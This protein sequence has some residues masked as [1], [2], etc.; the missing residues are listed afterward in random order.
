MI[1]ESMHIAIVLLLTVVVFIA[2]VRETFPPDVVAMLA[3]GV[4][5]V[6]GILTSKEALT[7]FSNAGPIAVG[8]MFVLSAAIERTG[9]IDRFGR[10]VIKSA[11]FSPILVLVAF[12]A[13]VMSL[14][15][16]IN[17]TPVVVI[18]TP[19]AVLLART[20]KISPSRLLIPL[21]Y[22]SIFGGTTTLIGT[23]TNLL[24]AGLVSESGQPPITMFEFTLPGV[25]M[26]LV[27]VAYLA[28]FGRWLLPDRTVTNVDTLERHFVTEFVVPKDSKL[29]GKSL[30]N[31][32]LSGDR[33]VTFLD[34]IRDGLSLRFGLEPI[35]LKAGD[36]VVVRSNA[37]DVMGLR[38][39]HEISASTEEP[40]EEN[41]EVRKVESHATRLMEG[42]VAPQSRLRGYLVSDLNFRRLFGVYIVAIYRQGSQL[43]GGFDKIVLMP[44]DTLLLEG[45][46]DGLR[47]LFERRALV[48]LTEPTDAPFRR[49]KAPI[50]AAAVILVM[51][52]A[53]FNIMP[54]EILA[55]VAAAVVVATGCLNTEEAYEAIQWPV[56]ML[57]FGM[58]AVGMAMEKTGAAALIVDHLATI[59]GGLGPILVVA[60]IYLVT[61]VLTEIVSNNA[62]AVLLTP[63]AVRLAEQMSVNPRPFI[64]AVLFAASASF[65]TPIGY[66]TNTFVY[67]VGGYKFSD[68]LRIGLPLNVINWLLGTMLIVWFWPL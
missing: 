47:R 23:S 11:G 39:A 10:I 1:P 34:L 59:A 7:V 16:F 57:I 18:L 60:M 33:G 38:E 50:A 30:A 55:L 62:S 13:V 63:I 14:S 64:M 3:F 68:F 2:F 20:M 12:L 49:D 53:A 46:A 24:I 40:G 22:A 5:V 52:L 66:Q 32:G 21:S 35:T 15:A 25:I 36:R 27:G 8:A 45:P 4:L 56:L 6:T 9:I 17:N 41:S 51:G 37:S 67:G 29:I 19:V 58:L 61:S 48:N 31:A 65:A 28:I 54:I 43:K 44:G 42:V 26:G